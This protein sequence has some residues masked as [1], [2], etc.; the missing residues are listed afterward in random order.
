ML[1]AHD[2]SLWYD[3]RQAPV[4]YGCNIELRAGE[5]LAIVGKSGGGK[6]TLL[7]LCAGLLPVATAGGYSKGL[8]VSGTLTFRDRPFRGPRPEFGYVPQNFA[9]AVAPWLS[10]RDNVLLARSAQLNDQCRAQTEKYL[11]RTGIRGVAH[12]NVTRLSGGQQQR[13]AFCRALLREPDVL[14]LDEPFANLDPT[15]RPNMGQLLR[16]I[17]EDRASLSVFLV[18][19]DLGGAGS[20]ADRVLAMRRRLDRPEYRVWTKP[21]DAREV[22]AWIAG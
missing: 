20:L 5:F 2:L 8:Q 14:F 1:V 15:L 7:R 19:H 13:V 16:Q 18:T 3:K 21:V 9:A 6:S 17:R 4:V 22:E 10:A 12:L 11:Q